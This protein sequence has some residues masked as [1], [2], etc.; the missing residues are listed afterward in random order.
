MTNPLPTFKYHPDPIGTGSIEKSDAT[1][2]VCSRARGFIYKGHVIADGDLDDALCPW[3]IADGSAH[4]RLGAEF[5]DSSYVGGTNGWCAVPPD[6]AREVATRT[7]S[8]V[9]WQNVYWFACCND[10]AAFLGRAGHAEIAASYASVEASLRAETQMVG[11]E[12]DA[13]WAEYFTS[14]DKDD[15]PTAYVFQCL[16]CGALGGFSDCH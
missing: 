2:V 10:A 6:V 11:A 5:A 3:C 14:L 8:F 12:H 7:P 9:P 4:E 16:H 13:D 15:S 1:C